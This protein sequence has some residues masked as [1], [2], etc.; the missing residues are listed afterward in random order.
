MVDVFGG[1]ML[2][3]EGGAGGVD[4]PEWFVERGPMI[5]SMFLVV[6]MMGRAKKKEEGGCGCEEE[7]CEKED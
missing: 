7:G 5:V 6:G 2:V 3:G 1:D 4:L